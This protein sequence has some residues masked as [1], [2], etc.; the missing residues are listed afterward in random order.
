MYYLFVLRIALVLIW[1][2]EWRNDTDWRTG[3]RWWGTC[4]NATSSQISN[5]MC[6]EKTRSSTVRGIQLLKP[7]RK[8]RALK[9]SQITFI[10]LRLS[11]IN[12]YIFHPLVSRNMYFYFIYFLWLCSPARA[13]ASS[14]TSFLDH[15]QRRATV[16]RNPLVEWLA[17]RR[18]LSLTTP[19]THKTNI[20]APGGIRMQDHSRRAAVDLR[21]RLRGHWERFVICIKIHNIHN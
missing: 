3:Y 16:G 4:P 2:W 5:G 17:R 20:H 15:T 9:F 14:S 19:N 7:S 8:F 10:N 21:F 12:L 6:L 13:M 11:I 1:R 18:D